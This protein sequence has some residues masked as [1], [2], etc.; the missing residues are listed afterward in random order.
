MLGLVAWFYI[1]YGLFARPFVSVPS[2]T[3]GISMP[4]ASREI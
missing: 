4:T 2:P 1:E 3:H